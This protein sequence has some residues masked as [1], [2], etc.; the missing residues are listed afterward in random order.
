MSFELQIREG[1][2]GR[3]IQKFVSGTFFDVDRA[4]LA[5][6]RIEMQNEDACT[7]QTLRLGFDRILG[8]DVNLPCGHQFFVD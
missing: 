4:H 7:R 8:P 6:L 1:F 5:I 2:D 3:I